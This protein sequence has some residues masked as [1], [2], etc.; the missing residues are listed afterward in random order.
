MFIDEGRGLTFFRDWR[1]KGRLYV[2]V[3]D[4]G[5]IIGGI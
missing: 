5:L 2:C 3:G 4:D 1:G